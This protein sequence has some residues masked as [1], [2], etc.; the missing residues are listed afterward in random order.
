MIQPNSLY[1]LRHKNRDPRGCFPKAP[2]HC[3]HH[4]EGVC[5]SYF[6]RPGSGLLTRNQTARRRKG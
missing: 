2:H 3:R 5:C 1:A 6:L 4:G